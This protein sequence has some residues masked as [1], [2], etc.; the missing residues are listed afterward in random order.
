MEQREIKGTPKY[1]LE[2]YA[3][4]GK[5]GE[6]TVI[7]KI[8]LT[9]GALPVSLIL[10]TSKGTQTH[11]PR[12]D[13]PQTGPSVRATSS[14]HTP[15]YTPRGKQLDIGKGRSSTCH[16]ILRT[17]K[18]KRPRYIHTTFTTLFPKVCQATCMLTTPHHNSDPRR[19]PVPPIT[20]PKKSLVP[21][22]LHQRSPSRRIQGGLV[23]FQLSQ[24]HLL[25]GA[26]C[27]DQLAKVTPC[28]RVP[29]TLTH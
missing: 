21:E 7:F 9:V 20:T 19:Y 25:N 10:P 3:D 6:L 8:T 2:R 22:C 23:N 11:H 29:H 5:R 26:T 13:E 12:C 28:R 14:T 18:R 1:G 27:S 24:P 17:V 15:N 16:V 4:H